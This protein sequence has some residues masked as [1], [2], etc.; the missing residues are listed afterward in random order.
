MGRDT[1]FLPL[2]HSL[3]RERR[4][5][6]RAELVS[7]NDF[8]VFGVEIRTVVEVLVHDRKRILH[9]LG[10]EDVSQLMD[11]RYQVSFRFL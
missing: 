4:G 7:P 10:A 6:K 11:K 1:A 8:P 5:E 3:S 9:V 2:R